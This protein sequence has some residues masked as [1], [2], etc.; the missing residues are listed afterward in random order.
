[1]LSYVEWQLLEESMMILEDARF[2]PLER[3]RLGIQRLKDLPPN[4]K[5][6]FVATLITL[7]TSMGLADSVKA[8]IIETDPS[9]AKYIMMDFETTESESSVLPYGYNL[10]LSKEGL[11]FLKSNYSKVPKINFSKEVNIAQEGVD[12]IFGDWKEQGK[13][14][15]L[16]QK[17]YDAIVLLTFRKGIDYVRKSE[18]IQDVK[19]GKH[20]QASIKL[21]DINGSKWL[22]KNLPKI[23]NHEVKLYKSY[24]ENEISAKQS[25][26]KIEVPKGYSV[27]GIDVSKYQGNIDWAKVKK[28]NTKTGIN[29]DFVFIKAT[30]ST[31]VDP[32]FKKNWNAAA[33][34][35]IARGAYHFFTSETSGAEQAENFIKTVKLEPGDLPPVL[36]Y[37]K[38]ASTKQ[39][40]IW[41]EM[42]EKHYGVKPIIYTG[43]TFYRD[44][45]GSEFDS[46]TLWVSHGPF[47]DMTNLNIPAPAT[48]R[49]WSFWQF[50]DKG[51]VPGID[52]K[53]DFNVFNGRLSDLKNLLIKDKR[54]ET[55][56]SALKKQKTT[57]KKNKG[58]EMS[59]STRPKL[60][61]IDKQVLDEIKEK[62]PKIFNSK[63]RK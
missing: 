24:L 19:L 58:A 36:D 7:A 17:M 11:N 48:S 28:M 51:T 18:F 26:V 31:R 42:I 50:S 9:S 60:D 39:V 57:E 56:S 47:N 13:H 21:S 43:A 27:H 62:N 14:I 8:E 40:K 6:T 10:K 35:D 30:Q 2:E 54:K 55:E 53:V 59:S 45:L 49:K 1:M 16:N 22:V 37:E 23:T 44:N 25:G 61:S 41:L 38:K 32:K 4:L 12:R 20:L 63:Y 33:N 15:Q 3:I 46:Y 5:K 34:H 29:I 52:A